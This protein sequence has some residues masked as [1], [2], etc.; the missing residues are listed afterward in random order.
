[1]AQHKENFD[2][3]A[4]VF[5]KIFI[6]G[7]RESFGPR[8]IFCNRKVYYCGA[9]MHMDHKQGGGLAATQLRM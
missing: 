3:T 2:A 5:R 8:I 6:N 7:G 9:G 4:K 1:M